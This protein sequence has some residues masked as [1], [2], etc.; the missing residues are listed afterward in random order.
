MSFACLLYHSRL[1]ASSVWPGPSASANSLGNQAAS[2]CPSSAKPQTPAKSLLPPLN[3]ICTN[4]SLHSRLQ[5]RRKAGVQSQNARRNDLILLYNLKVLTWESTWS[6]V[7]LGKGASLFAPPIS[8]PQGG[9]GLVAVPARPVLACMRPS[10]VCLRLSRT[11]VLVLL[12]LPIRSVGSEEGGGA[13]GRAGRGARLD[14]PHD[15]ALEVCQ[16]VISLGA[17]QRA[18]RVQGREHARLVRRL[19]GPPHRQ[20]QHE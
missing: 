20:Q 1:H 4:P 2:G 9:R 7:F 12:L 10:S 3:I 13:G 8:R 16:A 15:A 11:V 14:V 19:S 6:C 18:D 17:E 5:L